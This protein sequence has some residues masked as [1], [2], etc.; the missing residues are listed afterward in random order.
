MPHIWQ[1]TV[2]STIRQARRSLRYRLRRLLWPVSATCIRRGLTGLMPGGCRVL[3]MHSSLT[4]CGYVEGGANTVVTEVS[5]FC[6][7]ICMPTHT[8]C[9]PRAGDINAPVFDSEQTPSRVGHITDFFWRLPHVCRSRHPSHSL[10]VRGANAEGIC[11][12]HEFCQTP[13]GAGTPYQKLIEE[14]AAVLMFGTSM[15]TY[16]LFH[17]AEDAASCE[18]LYFDQPLMLRYSAGGATHSCRT[19]RQDMSVPRRFTEMGRVLEKEGL[20]RRVSLGRGE[21]LLVPSS[22]QTHEF[23]LEHLRRDPW[24]LAVRPMANVS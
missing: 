6:N 3:M 1:L 18:Y 24:Y 17:T 7:T 15:D 13:C 23:L 9:Y 5:R 22:R 19:W 2:S 20:L 4:A 8:Y 14:D 10:A 12:D 16:T 11:Q 21:L